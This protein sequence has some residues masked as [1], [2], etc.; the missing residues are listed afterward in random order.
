MANLRLNRRERVRDVEEAKVRRCRHVYSLS[1]SPQAG[2][3]EEK[4]QRRLA[5]SSTAATAGAVSPGRP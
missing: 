1:S 4:V 2:L 5:G 3:A